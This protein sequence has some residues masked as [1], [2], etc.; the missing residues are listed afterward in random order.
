MVNRKF[1]SSRIRSNRERYIK[2]HEGIDYFHQTVADPFTRLLPWQKLKDNSKVKGGHEWVWLLDSDAFIMNGEISGLAVIRSQIAKDAKNSKRQIDIIL[3]KDFNGINTG[4]LFIRSSKWSDTFMNKWISYENDTTIPMHDVW[5][6]QAAFIQMYNRNELSVREHLSFI[7]QRKINSYT[8]QWRSSN[9][10]VL[11]A[12]GLGYSGLVNFLD[13][14][15]L[16]E[17]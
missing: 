4:S 17:V 15:R 7:E 12:A 16:K 11:H 8:N 5:W 6:E 10:F 1:N 2:L 9:D 14:R 13:S 3:C